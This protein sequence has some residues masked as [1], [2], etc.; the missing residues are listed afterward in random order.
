MSDTRSY[1]ADYCLADFAGYGACILRPGHDGQHSDAHG[2]RFTMPS[3]ATS[4]TLT[5]EAAYAAERA[6]SRAAYAADVNPRAWR[7]LMSDGAAHSF[8]ASDVAD[9]FDTARAMLAP[10][11]VL[12][13]LTAL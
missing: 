11:V 4:A 1:P 8:E 9:A 2:Y 12:V 10:S 3:D 6:A 7:A 5:A 13:S